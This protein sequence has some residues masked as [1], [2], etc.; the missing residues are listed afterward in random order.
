M[1][2]EQTLLIIV[3]FITVGSLLFNVVQAIYLRKAIPLEDVDNLIARVRVYSLQT[4]TKADDILLD[5][6]DKLVAEIRSRIEAPANSKEQPVF[7]EEKT[8]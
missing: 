8:A 6:A 3:G 2:I 1:E 7:I 5:T 4:D